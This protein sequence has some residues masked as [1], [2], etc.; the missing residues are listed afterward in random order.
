MPA[1]F[2]WYGSLDGSEPIKKRYVVKASAVISE[3]EMLN[4]ESNE[5]DAGVTNDSNFIGPAC[6]AVDNTVDG[7]YVEAI[8]NP[9]A[10]YAVDDANARGIGDKLD[11]G[12]GGL[13]L[14]ADSNHDFIVWKSSTA[15]EPTLVIFNQT[16]FSQ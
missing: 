10:I 14:A 7:H 4:L 15:D 8:S 11:L 9:N 6:E 5:A 1:G 12:T 16:H 2:R 13:T 3:G